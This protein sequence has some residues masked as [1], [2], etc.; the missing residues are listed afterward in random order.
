VRAIT[1]EVVRDYQYVASLP[2]FLGLLWFRNRLGLIPGAWAVLVL[3]LLHGFVL[4][5]LALA[6]GYVSDRHV[7][8]LVL[9]GSFWGAALTAVI[10]KRI[11][12]AC[13]GVPAPAWPTVA[14]LFLLTGYC[15]PETLKP[16]HANRAGHH[17][18]GLWL[19]AHTS[20]ADPIEDPFCWAHYYAGRVLLEGKPI[21]QAEGYRPTQYAV[22]EQSDHEHIR[23]PTIGRAQELASRGEVVY[24]WPENVPEAQAKVCV[25]A[26]R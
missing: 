21:P 3:G 12:E 18:A 25:Y 13:H 4:W 16:L 17:A 11:A 14:L 26:V 19:A 24:W 2:V 20:P 6:V 8:L 5:R 22:L 15:I 10:G 23:L 7:L 1:T 9:C